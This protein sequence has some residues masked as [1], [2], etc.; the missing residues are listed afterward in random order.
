MTIRTVL[1]VTVL[2]LGCVI[3]ACDK[4]PTKPD[5]V[6][7][8][9]IAPASQSFSAEGGSGSIAITASDAS[10]AWTATSAA[11]WVMVGAGAGTGS[12]TLGYQV[13]SNTSTD[14]RATTVALGGQTH[15]VSQAGRTETPCT[16][17]IAPTSATFGDAGG[18]GSF[19]VTAPD[20]CAWTA[21]SSAP[22]AVVTGGASGSGNG[23]VSFIVAENNGTT[24]REAALVVADRSFAIMQLAEP[25]GP[26][27]CEYSVSPVLFQPC[28]AGNTVA[29]TV[30]APASCTWTA[31]VDV[32]WLT[33]LSGQSGNGTGQVTF[34]YEDNNLAP[35]LGLVMV[36]WPTPTAGQNVRVSQGGCFYFTG[37]SAFHHTPAGGSSAFDVF[38]HTIPIECGGTLP[39]RCVWA[40]VSNEPW[41]TITT[42]MPRTGADRVSFTVA[43]NASG[44]VRTGTI[45]VMDKTV[46]VV[47]GG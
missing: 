26:V 8:F 15:S 11:S 42:P 27:V 19:A 22:W 33:I 3:L 25:V 23:M 43:P 36:R 38:Q 35:R 28:M 47:Q 32:P 14:S 7:T 5:P 41:I 1:N 45:T 39:I 4:S 24:T 40:A 30:T 12:G 10:C 31:S 37:Q 16:Y 29:S 20:G 18:T 13:A 44:V 17:D 46:V 34:R 2:A 21:A 6:C 9:T